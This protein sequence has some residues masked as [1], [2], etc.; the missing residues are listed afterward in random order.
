MTGISQTVIARSIDAASP[1]AAENAPD[2]LSPPI[3]T[4]NTASGMAAASAESAID[5]SGLR[6]ATT[7]DG[8]FYAVVRSPGGFSSCTTN[9]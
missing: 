4:S 1:Q 3:K 2:F 6:V 9:Q 5:P 8:V 7:W